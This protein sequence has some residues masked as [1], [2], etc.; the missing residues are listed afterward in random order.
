MR[1]DKKITPS[2]CGNNVKRNI[3]GY[4]NSFFYVTLVLLFILKKD[5]SKNV[6]EIK[7]TITNDSTVTIPYTAKMYKARDFNIP[8]QFMSVLRKAS[9]FAYQNKVVGI[10][11]GELINFLPN[12]TSNSSIIFQLG[13]FDIYYG[14]QVFLIPTQWHKWITETYTRIIGAIQFLGENTTFTAASLSWSQGISYVPLSY[15]LKIR[16]NDSYFYNL[17]LTP[18]Y[19]GSITSDELKELYENIFNDYNYNEWLGLIV[20]YGV[21]YDEKYVDD[22]ALGVL[23]ADLE[24]IIPSKHILFIPNPGL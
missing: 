2:T 14:G 22:L 15:I 19:K 5:T 3:F 7:P 4:K 17:I 21:F 8:N 6:D 16:L 18:N 11:N 24:S 1:F 20:I 10:K 9:K 23:C 13:D 12:P